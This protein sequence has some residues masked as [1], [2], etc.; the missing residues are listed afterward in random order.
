MKSVRL[1]SLCSNCEKET[2]FE[3][4]T[5]EEIINVRKEPVKVE[6]QYRKCVECGDEVFDPNLNKDPFDLAYR[7]YRRKHSFLQP[8]EISD[9]RR[10]HGLKQSELAKLLGLGM[11]T[12]SRYENGALQDESHEKLFRLAMEPDN[13]LKLVEA[14]ENVFSETKKK[15]LVE[16]LREEE[17]KLLT[18]HSIFLKLPDYEP[19]EFSGYRALNVGKLY[20]AILY[21]CK[22]GV[23]KTKLNKLLFYADFR[24]F[25]EYTL[26]ITG[27]RYAHIP[28]GPAP[29]SY[30]FFYALLRST[31]AVEFIEKQYRNGSGEIIKAT[32]EADL[33]I[34]SPSEVRIMAAVKK[35]FKDY[36]AKQITEYSHEELGYK[37]IEDGHL[38]SYSYANLL[39]S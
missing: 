11:A 29:D 10:T 31:G 3:L 12:I 20:N 9:W 1:H 38:I 25:K 27:A 2:Q 7:E 34:F 4:V 21:F 16:S 6:V 15:R 30:D 23:F 26:S 19:D 35:D 33:S 39:N 5:K 28:F 17:D 13:L 32:K 37:E 14:S 22:E 8:E 24:H 36:N 18:E